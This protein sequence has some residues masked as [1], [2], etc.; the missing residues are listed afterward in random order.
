[1]TSVEKN[2]THGNNKGSK[3]LI[4]IVLYILITI[5]VIGSFNY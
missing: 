2:S 5:I 3:S 4:T 1:M